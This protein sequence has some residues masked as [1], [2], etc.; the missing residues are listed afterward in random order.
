METNPFRVFTNW[1]FDGSRNSPLPEPKF[2]D[3]GKVLVPDILK[4][5]SPITYTFVLQLFM[6]N[7]PMNDYLNRHFN[8]INLRY[9]DKKEFLLF[10]KECVL[11]F[12]I[13]KWD[14]VYYKFDRRDKLFNELRNRLPHL[15]N[16]DIVLL[17]D[18]IEKSDE[19][20]SIYHTIG[21]EIPKKKRI[22]VHKKKKK[23]EKIP[24]S[25]L[26]EEHFSI[27]RKVSPN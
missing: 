16:N 18:L 21:L 27:Y 26:L 14:T 1:L 15:K 6:K 17:C 20:E 22:R 12:K 10:I 5:N 23:K 7:G 24:L 25:D 3:E 2:T 9:L 19:K 8:N 13:K 11:D 4:Y